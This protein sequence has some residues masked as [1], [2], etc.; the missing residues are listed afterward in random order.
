M[1]HLVSELGAEIY[2][3]AA[4]ALYRYKSR[5]EKFLDIYKRNGF[6]GQESISGPGSSL[7]QTRAI[8]RELPALLKGLHVCSLLD[9]PCGDFHWMKELDPDVDRYVGADIVPDLIETNQALY[10][11]SRRQFIVSDITRDPVPSFDLILC[12]DCFI[13]LSFKDI[14][15]VLRNF[16]RSRSTYLLTTTFTE[17]LHN[18]NIVTGR[19]RPVNLRKAPFNFPQPLKIINEECMEQ[20]GEYP[21]KSLGLWKIDEALLRFGERRDIYG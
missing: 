5:R 1:N 16:H 8:R 4:H 14:R 12:R 21:D 2:H 3:R 18:R 15:R 17:L 20:G 9:A 13:H 6:G 7:L 11:N 10:G 19:V